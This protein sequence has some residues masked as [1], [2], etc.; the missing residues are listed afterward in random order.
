MKRA[1]V[2]LALLVAGAFAL[3]LLAHPAVEGFLFGWLS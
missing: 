3:E 2:I 1:L